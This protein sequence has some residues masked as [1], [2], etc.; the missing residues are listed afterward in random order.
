MTHKTF[1]RFLCVLCA[2]AVCLSFSPTHAQDDINSILANMTLEQKVGQMFLASLYGEQLT[3]V[4]RAFLQ[5]YQPGGVVVF[6]YNVPAENAPESVT[7][8]INTFQQ[9]TID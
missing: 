5:Q 1:S 7:A 2:F 3:E 9:T 6:E 8:L 4:G